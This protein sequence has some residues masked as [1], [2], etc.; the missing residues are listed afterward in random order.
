MRYEVILARSAAEDYQ[1]L[2]ARWRSAVKQALAVHL[3]HE[4][5]KVSKSRIKR[6]RGMR[7]PQYR[8]RVDAVRVFYDVNEG[9]QRVEV[10]G[11]V[12]KEQAGQWLQQYGVSS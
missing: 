7:R 10:I 3:Q 11:I 5:L 8:L 12:H 6:L 4:P 2:D 9:L 1:R